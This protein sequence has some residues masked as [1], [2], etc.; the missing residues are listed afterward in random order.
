[1]SPRLLYCVFRP[2]SG[3]G[4]ILAGVGGRP[5]FVRR[6]GK[7]AAA[8]SSVAGDEAP[9]STSDLLLYQE[10]V[11][12]FNRRGTVV[13]MRYGAVFPSPEAL[14]RH[15]EKESLRYGAL[16]DALEDGV[17]MGVR[18]LV[19]ARR[20]DSPEGDASKDGERKEGP[21]F[22]SSP[23]KGKSY[24]LARRGRY[25]GAREACAAGERCEEAFA[26]LYR[27]AKREI[28]PVKDEEGKDGG[29]VLLSVYFLVRRSEVEAFRHAFRDFLNREGGALLLSG[30]WA[31]YSF[32]TE[33]N[34]GDRGW[35]LP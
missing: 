20:D 30:P 19:S 1:M 27:K 35:E 3:E 26:G 14:D 21:G 4:P 34:G 16:L 29:K 17:E 7:L 11:E 15:L 25:L 12:A 22:P 13:P 10:V 6:K 5:V 33:E 31:P 23:G 18:V 32:V 9:R 24:L 2:E 28:R 8:A